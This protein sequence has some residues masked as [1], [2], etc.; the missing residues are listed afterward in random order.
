M[1]TK[2]N[3]SKSPSKT[4]KTYTSWRGMID[5][6]TNPKHRWYWKYKD[7]FYSPWK[8]YAVF[9]NDMGERPEN[10]TLDRVDNALGY[11]PDNCRWATHTQ[12]Q[13]NKSNIK[14]SKPLADEVR[15][16]WA[17]GDYT[18]KQLAEKFGTYNSMISSVLHR[19]CWK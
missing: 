4:S 11:G 16:L 15:D 14:F 10:T 3:R 5:R 12:Q 13:R 8:E 9:L 18:V 1:Q 6:C 2:P 17:T 7:F 19:G